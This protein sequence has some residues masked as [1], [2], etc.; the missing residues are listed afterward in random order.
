MYNYNS[1]EK[2]QLQ[3]P[4]NGSQKSLVHFP[5]ENEK[6]FL[7]FEFIWECING[8]L[9]ITKVDWSYN[10][11]KL[12]LTLQNLKDNRLKCN[13]EKSFFGQTEIR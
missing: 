13:V 9:I 4:T 3:T 11:D 7:G 1:L 6:M 5:G 2:L 12:E 10:L 8:L